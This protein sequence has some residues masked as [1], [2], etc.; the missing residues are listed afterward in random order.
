ML[1]LALVIAFGVF[2]GAGLSRP[3][4]L[5]TAI[6]LLAVSEMSPSVVEQYPDQ[7]ESDRIDRIGLAIA[8]FAEKGTK[9]VSA[10]SPLSLVADG[11]CVE[12]EDVASSFAVDFL[13]LPLVLSA[14]SAFLIRRT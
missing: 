10:L 7:L 2:L 4:A 5:F 14:L 13:L 9:S 1:S 6:V 11:D 3:V 12:A 8:R